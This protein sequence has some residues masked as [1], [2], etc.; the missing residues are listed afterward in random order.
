MLKK[1]R[2]YPQANLNEQQRSPES[3][4]K[5]QNLPLPLNESTEKEKNN[6]EM[7]Q[8]QEDAQRILQR[9][10]EVTPVS[11]PSTEIVYE[12]KAEDQSGKKSQSKKS[13]GRVERRKAPFGIKEGATC[14]VAK[15]SSSD[16][17]VRVRTVQKKEKNQ[18]E[19]NINVH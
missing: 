13:N 8:V 2:K 9:K 17:P 12:K 18:K 5:E 19:M 16:S 11:N 10:N 7:R 14:H 4:E 6:E 15:T 1:E 3:K